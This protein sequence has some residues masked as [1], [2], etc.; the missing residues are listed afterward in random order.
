MLALNLITIHRVRLSR[1]GK[2]S[3]FIDWWD[4]LIRSCRRSSPSAKTLA[5]EHPMFPLGGLSPNCASIKGS[6]CQLENFT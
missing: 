5:V 6:Q 1:R 3:N 2:F 4:R